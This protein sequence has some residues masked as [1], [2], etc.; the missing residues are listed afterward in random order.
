[1][2]SRSL[3][4]PT[5]GPVPAASTPQHTTAATAVLVVDA[6]EQV[7]RIEQLMQDSTVPR[8][9]VPFILLASLG[10][11]PDSTQDKLLIEVEER[12]QNTG[13]FVHPG[14]GLKVKEFTRRGRGVQLVFSEGAPGNYE[15]VHA[16]TFAWQRINQHL[17]T[18]QNT[19]KTGTA[20]MVPQGSGN[21]TIAGA[22]SPPGTNVAVVA[23]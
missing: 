16:T 17:S 7:R 4:G 13:G 5:S 15:V 1:M 11:N 14:T 19:D 18:M 20:N 23:T 8:S 9:L 3:A 22:G 10:L 2:K 21:P 6:E 12:M